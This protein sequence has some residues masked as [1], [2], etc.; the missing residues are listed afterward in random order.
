[1]KA[2]DEVEYEGD[3]DQDQDRQQAVFHAVSRA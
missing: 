3:G 2:V 1:V